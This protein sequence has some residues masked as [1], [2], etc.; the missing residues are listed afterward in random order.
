LKGASGIAAVALGSSV[1]WIRLADVEDDD[2][3]IEYL[4]ASLATPFAF[5]PRSIGEE[6]YASGAV[7]DNVPLR[8]LLSEGCTQAVVIHLQNGS[9]WRRMEF[10]EISVLEIRPREPIEEWSLPLAGWL[11][12]TFDFSAS[13]IAELDARGYDDANATLTAAESVIS[14]SHARHDARNEMLDAIDRL[15]PPRD[16]SDTE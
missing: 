3:L 16:E 5:P 15:Q 9:A 8:A 4:L 1:E 2:S 14:L 6:R 11:R 10:P 12:A 7:R 13:R